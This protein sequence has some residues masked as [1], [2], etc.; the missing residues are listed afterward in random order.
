MGKLYVSPFAQVDYNLCMAKGSLEEA[1]SAAGR[2]R[3]PLVGVAKENA[4][5]RGLR[6]RD[7]CFPVPHPAEL[8]LCAPRARA[9][10]AAGPSCVA[11]RPCASGFCRSR[12]QRARMRVPV[13]LLLPI[14]VWPLRCAP[15]SCLLLPH[16]AAVYALRCRMLLLLRSSA[17]SRCLGASV[18]LRCPMPAHCCCF[19]AAV[20]CGPC[21][22]AP[23]VAFRPCACGLHR[24]R[25]RCID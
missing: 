11:Y 25:R 8:A 10:R 4:I 20:P 19:C 5:R 12:R 9:A 14:S 15:A 16:W 7:A 21:R 6:V 13:E 1:L 24:L 3:A 17:S 23:Y 2:S 22:C 18:A